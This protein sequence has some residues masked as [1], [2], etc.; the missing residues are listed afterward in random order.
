MK[1]RLAYLACLG[2]FAP[3]CIFV[4]DDGGPPTRDDAG[5]TDGS[6][7]ETS[8]DDD[9]DDAADETGADVADD[10]SGGDETAGDDDGPMLEC[11]AQAL[12]DPGFEG[13]TP[14]EAWTEASEMFGS[15]LCDASCT[16]DAG[17]GPLAG[18]WYAWFGGVDEAERASLTQS[19]I[20]TGDEAT[21]S[22]HLAI[23]AAS[24]TGD[25]AL[26][27]FV[28]DTEVFAVGD[29]DLD[30]YSDYTE[31][32]IDVS[33]WADGAEHTLSIEAELAGGG[34]TSFFVDELSVV[35]CSEIASEDETGG[36]E[37]GDE[38]G[39]GTGDETGDGTGGDETAGDESGGETGGDETAG[40][41]TGGEESG[42][43]GMSESGGE[44]GTA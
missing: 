14:N 35:A 43:A 1:T 29:G 20:A 38:T 16:E 15:P 32:Q 9:D 12:G 10:T 26:R 42:D 24:G 2:L 34:V 5:D 28:D 27:V 18:D 33:E 19:F 25:D 21:L 44:S 30:D 39:D 4:A 36:D 22:M 3:A 13:G 31:V 11:G 37:T 40:E 41:E 17:A 6:A 8:G 23:N 7:D